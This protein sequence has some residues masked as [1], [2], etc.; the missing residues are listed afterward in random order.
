MRSD[1]AIPAG[2]TRRQILTGAGTALTAAAVG[3]LTG[4]SAAHAAGTPAGQG[5]IEVV[6]A[7]ISNWLLRI[8]TVRVLMDTYFS[9]IPTSVFR[10]GPTSWADYSD[11]PVTPDTQTV[12]SIHSRLGEYRKIDYIFTGHSHFDHSLDCAEWMKL[13]KAQLVG[14]R[15]T[16]YQAIAWGTPEQRCR[17]VEGGEIIPLGADAQVHVIRWNHGGSP[18]SWIHDPIELEEVPTPEPQN[19][20]LRIGVGEDFPNGGGSRAFLFTAG[21]GSKRV[22]MLWMNTGS[23]SDLDVPIVVNGTNFGAPSDNLRAAMSN[24]D[25]DRVDLAIIPWWADAAE[26]IA[27]I[28]RP[29]AAIPNH[30]DG[31]EHPF[32][33][34]QPFQFDSAELEPILASHGSQLILPNQYLDAW[35]LDNRGVRP[36]VNDHMQRRFGFAA[37]APT[38]R[39]RSNVQCC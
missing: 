27:A 6:W 35:T 17:I 3:A 8:G 13:C 23:A 16:A 25:I 9:R 24:A 19:G 30:W 37:A 7:S 34:G 21:R 36:K 14:S 26:R 1:S 10:E 22:S 39:S 38:S 15:S 20:G 2:A 31:L 18:G 32:F 5:G 29:R 12:R 4:P 33:E 11:H 28:A